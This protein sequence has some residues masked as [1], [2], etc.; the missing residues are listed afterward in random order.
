M[1]PPQNDGY[2]TV[3][4][5][6]GTALDS[7]EDWLLGHPIAPGTPLAIKPPER[8]ELRCRASGAAQTNVLKVRRSPP[9][10][11]RG[12]GTVGTEHVGVFGETGGEQGVGVEWGFVVGDYVGDYSADGGGEI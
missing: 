9:G 4:N 11:R 6:H 12:G 1:L 3:D 10:V 2:C 8:V 5:V 7:R